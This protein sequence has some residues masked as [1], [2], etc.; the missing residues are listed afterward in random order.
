M[1][2][3][4]KGGHFGPGLFKFLRE[5]KAHND[6]TWFQANKQR[7]EAEVKRPMIQFI[8]DFGSPL[9][10]VSRHYV[11]D[12]RPVGG[13]LFRIYRD[14]RFSKDKSPYKTYA[15]AHFAHAASGKDVHAPGFYLHLQP[16]HSFAAGGVWRP[17]PGALAKIRDAIVARPRAWK[18]VVGGKN[19][20]SVE[21]ESLKRPP[22]GYDPQHALI[23]DLKR[24][25][26][27]ASVAISDAVVTGPR[28]LDAYAAACKRMAPLMAFLTEAM[29]LP[30]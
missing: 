8:L 6:R 28:F 4:K 25:D 3:A 5:L 26:F 7:Y 1:A 24:K 13:S 10:K 30:W 29:E 27:I 15:S 11:A 21:G 23:A 9:K 19:G 18:A 22:Q 16:G 17:E 14:T 12:A 2:A 20:L